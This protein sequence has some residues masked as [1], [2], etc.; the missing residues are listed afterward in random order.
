MTLIE[1]AS[2]THMVSAG[3]VRMKK[4]IRLLTFST[5]YPNSQR[6]AHGVFVE[7]RL[8]H[9]VAGGEAASTVLAPVPW[10]PLRSSSFGDWARHAA[11]PKQDVRYGLAMHH[12]RYPVIPRIGMSVA[13][14][15]LYRAAAVAV[16]K[17]VAGGLQFDLIDAHYLYPDGVAA[18][19]LG[20]RF[21][22]PVVVTARGSDV[23]LLPRYHVPRRLI[24][25]AIAGADALISVSAGLKE[26]LVA[27]GAPADKVMVLRNGVDLEM[28]HPVIDRAAARA[29]LGLGEGPTLLSA[30]HL[31]ER[32]GHNHVIEAL[33]MLPGHT[34]VVVGEGPERG[35]LQ[36]LARRLGVADRVRLLGACPHYRMPLYYTAADVLV[37]ASSREGWANVLLEAMACGTPVVASPAWGSREAVRAPEAGLVL[38]EVTAK[39]IADGVRHLLAA[40]PAREATRRYAAGFGWDETTAGQ[41]AVFRRVLGQVQ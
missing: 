32:K 4:P 29:E 17:L 26:G 40:P 18:V 37:L 7:N 21:G 38:G 2:A 14:L 34:L 24:Q 27:L 41:I 36:D 11:V 12:P 23:S 39:A 31:I 9:L 20:R 15:L 30:G 25:G 1:E 3:S 13:P 5:L 16:E 28:F 6:P 10:F 35:A 8:R 22:K 33:G 19:W